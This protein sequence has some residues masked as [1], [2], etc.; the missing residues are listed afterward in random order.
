M[1]I[2]PSP[3]GVDPPTDWRKVYIEYL[4]QGTFLADRSEATSVHGCFKS[5][6][7]IDGELYKCNI[8]RIKQRCI[9]TEQGVQLPEDIH[10]DICGHHAAP[11]T[12]I[13]NAFRYGFYWLTAVGDVTRNVRSYQ[14]Y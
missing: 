13:G 7:M 1:E 12:L 6:V 3:I 10:T 11:K 9:P 14:G 5:Y 4:T 2:D 8:F